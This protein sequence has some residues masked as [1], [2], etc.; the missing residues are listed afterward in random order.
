MGRRRHCVICD[1]PESRVNP[2]GPH[3]DGLGP[4]CLGGCAGRVE[5]LSKVRYVRPRMEYDQA[6]TWIK[7]RVQQI[8]RFP[9]G[10]CANAERDEEYALI[11][12]LRAMK[13]LAGCFPPEEMIHEDVPL[14]RED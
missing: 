12:A 9:L 11:L 6:F 14:P 10:A 2:L 8:Q 13:D 5:T 3:P 4:Y 7:A 1:R